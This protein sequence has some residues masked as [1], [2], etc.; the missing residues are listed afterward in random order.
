VL[1]IVRAMQR[2]KLTFEQKILVCDTY[3]KTD[4]CREVCRQ[5]IEKFP[6]VPVPHRNTVRNL[7]VRL[8]QSAHYILPAEASIIHGR[9]CYLTAENRNKPEKAEPS[10]STVVTGPNVFAKPRCK[11]SFYVLNIRLEI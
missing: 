2:Q 11:L 6:G 4:S 7:V 1:I 3:V 10:R 5:F 8:M 9:D